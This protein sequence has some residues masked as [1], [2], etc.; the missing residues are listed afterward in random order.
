VVRCR[1]AERHS[2][3]AHHRAGFR[4]HSLAANDTACLRQD[5]P[6]AGDGTVARV[7]DEAEAAIQNETE[8]EI[9]ADEIAAQHAVEA[10]NNG[11]RNNGE[12]NRRHAALPEPGAQETGPSQGTQPAL[13][14][15]Q[16][17]LWPWVS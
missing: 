16:L 13:H 14:F 1:Q 11:E 17:S 2:Y 4:D 9:A 8:D 5:G 3:R 7:E 10:R 12:Q 15:E 6:A